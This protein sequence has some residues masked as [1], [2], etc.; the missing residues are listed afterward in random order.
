MLLFHL[1]ASFQS[2]ARWKSWIGCSE[3]LET[4]VF[5]KKSLYRGREKECFHIVPISN[6]DYRILMWITFISLG[7]RNTVTQNSNYTT[8]F[9]VSVWKYLH[10]ITSTFEH[11]FN[12]TFTAV[13]SS[14]VQVIHAKA[15]LLV[16]PASYAPKAPMSFPQK[17]TML[18]KQ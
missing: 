11:C 12:C 17:S 18:F 5:I 3:G 10:W 7:I 16:P 4:L 2:E 6:K 13:S 14:W 9:H 8:N 15:P 1:P